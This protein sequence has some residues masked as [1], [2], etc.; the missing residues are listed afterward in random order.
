MTTAASPPGLRFSLREFFLSVAAVA[1][2][3]AA[4]KYA[5]E[6]WLSTITFFMIL[7]TMAAAIIALVDRGPRQASATGFVVAVCIYV[8]LLNGRSSEFDPYEGTLPTSQLLRPLYAVMSNTWY[9]DQASGKRVASS[10]LPPESIIV[11]SVSG[12]DAAFAAGVGGGMLVRGQRTGYVQW[13]TVSRA[14]FM[15]IAHLLWAILFG[16]VA[17]KFARWVYAHRLRERPEPVTAAP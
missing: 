8:A 5:N 11:T 12:G 14:H 16:Y 10:D 7:A 1:V 15:R 2:S 4:L 13:E 6:S 17:A 3:C 9:I